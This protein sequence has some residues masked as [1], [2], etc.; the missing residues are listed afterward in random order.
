MPSAALDGIRVIDLSRVLAGPYCAMLLADYGAD[1]IKIEQPGSGDPTR[2]WGPPWLGDQSAYYLTANRNKRGLTLDLKSAAGQGVARRLI[3]SADVVVEN[4]LPG[5][6]ARWGLDYATL[7]AG[8]PGLIYC[9]ITGYGQTGP[10]RDR[11][12]YDFM[13]QAE[14]GIMSITGPA[15]GEPHKVGVAIV[16]ISAGLFAASAI[17][18]ALHHRDRTGRGQHIDVALL[19]AQL[20]WLANVASNYLVG[21]EP[22]ARYGNAHPNIVPYEAFPTADGYIAVGIGSDAQYRRF[23]ELAGRPDLWDEPRYQTNAGRVA[24]RAELITRLRE[25]FAARPAAEWLAALGAARIP[26]API[27]DIPTTLADPH[28]RAR[29]QVQAVAHPTLGPVPQVGPVAR[30]SETPATVRA[31]PPMLG[32]HTDAILREAGYADAQI[33]ELRRTGVI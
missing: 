4:F 18:A 29:G 13:I 5:A 14:G 7:A 20:G 10:Y 2:A 28:V 26:A 21:G 27:N 16:D 32:E 33:D 31:A 9:S 23:C 1:V 17:L 30:L 6:L 11:P 15:D 12:G 24:A 19:D 8:Q 3:A 25:V 22:P